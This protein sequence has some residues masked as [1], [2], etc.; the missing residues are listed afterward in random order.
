MTDSYQKRVA[1][2]CGAEIKRS[3][4]NDQ[5]SLAQ[6]AIWMAA[7]LRK[8]NELRN[9]AR[10]SQALNTQ[11]PSGN[12]V[13]QQEL[14]SREDNSHQFEHAPEQGS[15]AMPEPIMPLIGWTIHGHSWSTYLGWIESDEKT[16]CHALFSV[17]RVR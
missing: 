2:F 17:F 3:G 12:S 6:L 10:S 16:V 13:Q 4:G 9:D 7:G 1:L 8:M 15:E 11:S 5:E 14:T